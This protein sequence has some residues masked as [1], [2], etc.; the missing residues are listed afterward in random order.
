MHGLGTGAYLK[1]EACRLCLCSWP[2]CFHFG[3][4][5]QQLAPD[6]QLWALDFLGQGRSWPE[7]PEGLTYSVDLWTEQVCE[8]IRYAD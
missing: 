1:C 5:M 8:F 2:G 6:H 7:Q 4:L 3:E